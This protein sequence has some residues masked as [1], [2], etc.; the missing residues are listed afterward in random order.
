MHII[1]IEALE[2]GAHR[3]QNGPTLPE[4]PEGWA[5]IP[6]GMEI[7]DTYPFVGVEAEVVSHQVQTGVDEEG[8]PVY[9]T[10][11]RMEVTSLTAGVVPEP[12]PMPER[13][14]TAEEDLMGMAVDH[15]MRL[16]MLELGV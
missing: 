12:E 3:Q 6:E 1:E 15:E 9:T 13:E 5:V 16:T 10:I 8:N 2:N 11:E 4:I 14:P 7:P